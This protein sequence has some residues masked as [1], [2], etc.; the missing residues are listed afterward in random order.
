MEKVIITAKCHD[1]LQEQLARKGY[2]VLYLPEITY[3]D[4]NAIVGEA[5]GLILSTRLKID[6]PILDNAINLKWIGRLGSGLE[7]IDVEYARSKG[8]KVESSPEG[9]RDAVGEHALAMLLGLMNK[10]LVSHLEVKDFIWKREANRG[11]ELNGK[12]VGIIGFGNAGSAFAKKLQ[13]FDVTILAYDKYKFGFAS[14]NI[15]EASLEQVLKY[16]DVVSLYVPLTEETFHMAN[17]DFFNA[18]EQK[19]WFI[20][21]CR[22]KVHETGAVINALQNEKISGAALDVLENEKL[23]T[24]SEEEKQQLRWLSAR[25]NVIITPHIAGYSHEAFYKMSKILLQKLGF[26]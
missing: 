13:G 20:N 18:M 5:E 22:G 21:T 2:D 14:G 26:L 9:N 24:Y 6:K 19:P 25:P 8:I 4:L 16:S 12:T 23:S 11:W 10:I 17:D 3:E 1:I 15:K 7:L